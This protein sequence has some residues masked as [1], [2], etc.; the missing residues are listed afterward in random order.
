MDA[1]VFQPLLVR[2]ELEHD[3]RLVVAHT[4]ALAPRSAMV[5]TDLPLSIGTSVRVCL[6]FRNLFEPVAVDARVVATTPG[7]GHGYFPGVTLDLDV[8]RSPTA[9]RT[10]AAL[11][12]NPPR[13]P[14]ECRVLVVEDSEIM[15]ECV[16][17]AAERFAA[18]STR[19]RVE[20]A[21]SAEDA[22]TMLGRRA[23][24]FVLV[25]HYLAGAI[26]GADFIREVRTHVA[27]ELPMVGFS[28]GGSAVREALLGAGADLFLEKPVMVRDLLWTG[29]RLLGLRIPD[30]H[31]KKR[32]LI[33]D[34]SVIF[35]ELAA[36]ALRDAGYEVVHATDLKELQEVRDQTT[37]DLVLMDV[38][39][40]EAFGDDVALTL[41][42]VHG[43]TAPIYLLSS[44]DDVDL[45]SRVRWAQVEGFISKN[46][47]LEPMIR[48]VQ[49]I[50]G[51]APRTT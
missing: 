51:P 35:L 7:A 45:A 31:K 18:T 3:G 43:I 29:A 40:P 14:P 37:A 44:L 42:H 22:L 24:D 32:V 49:R 33:M 34:D 38:Q 9:A 2:A 11:L 19:T 17:V 25:D 21:A 12:E 15:Q 10:I 20:A 23:F 36:M 48:E 47:G 41:R 6:S 50:L 27:A 4:T 13:W 30:T 28:V 16:I 26:T 46:R 39:M 8:D 1:M 5:R